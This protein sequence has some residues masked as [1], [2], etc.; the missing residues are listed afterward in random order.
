MRMRRMP[1][2]FLVVVCLLAVSGSSFDTD[3]VEQLIDA[4][5]QAWLD[6]DPEAVGAFF[7]DEAVFVDLTGGETVGREAIVRYADSHVEWIPESRRTGPVEAQED[8]T[9]VYPGHL[10][11]DW[12]FRSGTYTGVVSVAIEDGLFARYDLSQLTRTEGS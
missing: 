12:A 5:D 7:A 1:I 8:G 3:A 2:P 6:N 9:F 4:H 10:E 11:V